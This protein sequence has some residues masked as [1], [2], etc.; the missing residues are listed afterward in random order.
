MAH[1][2]GGSIVRQIESLFEGCSVT[3]LSDRQL[4][5]RFTARR[6]ATGEAAFAALVARHGPMVLGVCHRFLGDRHHAEDAFQAVFLVLARKALSIR[7]H[8]RLSTWLY[9]VAIRTAR[10]ANVR[11]ALQRRNEEGDAMGRPRASSG[12][13]AA[14]EPM[15]QPAE[16]SILDREQAE[17]LH[18]EIDRLATRFRLP[19]VLCYFEGLTL[20]EAARRLRCPS[21]TLRSRLARA[22]NK[23]RRGL[24]RRG[25]A[26]P[27]AALAAALSPQSASARISS[28]LCAITTRAAIQFAA[29]QA[30]R[31]AVSV[32]AMALAQEVLRSMLFQKL[33]LNVLALL[34]L[35]AVATGAGLVGQAP[36]RQAAE[37]ERRP[38]ATKPDDAKPKPAPGRMFV[39]GRVLDPGGKPVSNASVMVYAALKQRADRLSAA[40]GPSTNGQDQSG[41]SGR[42]RLDAPRTSSSIHY[43]VGV[44]AV[45]PGFGTGWI[46]IDPDAEQPAT[47]ITLRPEQVI[48]GRAFD[49]QGGPAAGVAI[50]VEGMGHASR[51]PESLPFEIEGAS[52]WGGNRATSPTAG[53]PEPVI[54]DAAGRFTIHGTGRGLRVLLIADGPRFARQQIVVDTDNTSDSKAITTTMEPARVFTGRV[55]YSDTGKPAPHAP[56]AIVAHR[57]GPGYP[58]YFETDGDG[59]V[60][61]NPFS[62]DHYRLSVTAPAGEPYLN[63]GTQLFAWNKGAVERRIDIALHR[64]VLIHGKVT[65]EGSGRPVAGATIAY[66]G[67]RNGGNPPGETVDHNGDAVSAPDGSYQFAV[68]PKPGTMI[69]LGPSEDFVL[70][71]IGDRML[72]EGQPGGSRKYSHAFLAHDLKPGAGP[73]EVNIT[74]RRGITVKGHVIGPDG[75]PVQDAW[76]LSRL[77]VQPQPWPERDWG[78]Q[79]HGNVHD[80]RLELHG[81]DPYAEVPVYFL[82]P[83]HKLGATVNLSGKS[84]AVMTI[85]TNTGRVAVGATVRFSGESRTRGPITVRLQPCGAARARVVD[86]TG[87]PRAAYRDPFMFSMV[88]TPSSDRLSSTPADKT[89]LSG[90]G[91]YLFRIDPINYP[92]G[93]LA[94]T[95]GRLEFPALIPGATYRVYDDS[96]DD[97]GG[98]QTRKEFTVKPGETLDLGDILIEKPPE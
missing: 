44:A 33:A 80:G 50:A 5:E 68:L 88:V 40:T 25:V 59:Q 32:S 57:G 12:L 51:S 82:D 56:I 11:V 67:P 71:P 3:G 70:Q 9:G 22:R 92:A 94:D 93:C 49:I 63:A 77:L 13:S 35:G 52:F 61:A 16:Q 15:V 24:I 1:A 21:G 65:E 74:L 2:V 23:L 47:D 62:T 45:A 7:D 30:A 85:A 89:A 38:I 48:L 20:D 75:Q 64:G 98:R 18:N 26:L 72:R 6:D 55:T 96:V 29:G 28:P 76:I 10:N 97:D 53:W 69:V 60:H 58:S 73:Q 43:G 83:K 41:E 37:P 91:D 8:N 19:V 81:L 42:F 79:F 87:K 17:I 27:A 86:P 39:V 34:L 90:D 95:E 14:V 66:R 78:G 84:I 54:S 36:A 4:L 31:E 46:E